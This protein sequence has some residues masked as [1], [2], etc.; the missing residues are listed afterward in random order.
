MNTDASKESNMERHRPLVLVADDDEDILELVRF[1]LARSGY[2]T[3]CAH[4]GT[5]ALALVVERLPDVVVLDVSM[6]G[7]DGVGVTERM[8]SDE[9]TKHIPVILLT[10]RTNPEDVARGIAAGAEDYVTKPFSP[11]M[12]ESRVSAVL[13]AAAA[14]RAPNWLNHAI[15]R[16]GAVG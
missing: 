8:R 5:Q 3:I 13:K 14:L 16:A 2:D 10:A 11:E 1:R 9:S 15:R 4:D 6:P 12:L 7:L